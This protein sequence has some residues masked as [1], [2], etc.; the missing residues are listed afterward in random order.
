MNREMMELLKV[1]PERT[2]GCKRA[3]YLQITQSRSWL[4]DPIG[5]VVWLGYD[6]PAT[7]PH[8]PF[9][10]G[11]SRMPDSYMVDGRTGYSR[12]CAWWAFRKVSQLAMLYWQPMCQSIA[13]VWSP[14]EEKAFA[15]QAKV[16]E[17]AVLLYE[18]NPAKAR[19]FLTNYCIKMAEG[20]VAAYWKLEEDL[21]GSF[22]QNF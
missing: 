19:E 14:I 2:I 22:T 4:P 11:I 8:T 20:A 6:N 3:T 13:K 18:K 21:W 9:Y 12:N 17:E 7:T 5:G 16:E 1:Q 10:C 15:D